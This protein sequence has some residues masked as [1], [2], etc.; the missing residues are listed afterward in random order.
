M[1]LSR[2]YFESSWLQ[3]AGAA[4]C[5]ISRPSVDGAASAG[6]QLVASRIALLVCLGFVPAAVAVDGHRRGGRRGGAAPCWPPGWPRTRRLRLLWPAWADPPLPLPNQ[7]VARWGAPSLTLEAASGRELLPWAAPW[8]RLF[9]FWSLQ[10]GSTVAL[11]LSHPLVL[12]SPARG[13]AAS[14][15]SSA[16]TSL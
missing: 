3:V 7:C 12:S 6:P 1:S 4:L 16:T 13:G 9:F 10:T 15:S 2:K 8:R 5:G 11:R 14:S